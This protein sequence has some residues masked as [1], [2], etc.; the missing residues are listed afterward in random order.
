MAWL[1]GSMAATESQLGE[2]F[3]A[4]SGAHFGHGL[5]HRFLQCLG[6]LHRLDDLLSLFEDDL[7]LGISGEVR[8]RRLHAHGTRI[9]SLYDT[10]I[11]MMK[12]LVAQ[13]LAMIWFIVRLNID[14][15]E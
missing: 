4:I 15:V 11:K 6:K 10:N 12:F 5:V 7:G 8:R 1:H 9:K 3:L 14:L 13:D 2:S